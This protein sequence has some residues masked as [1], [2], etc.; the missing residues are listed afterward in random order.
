MEVQIGIIQA[1]QSQAAWL[2]IP[3]RIFSFLGL[4]EFYLLV[5][6]LFYWC[7][8]PRFGLRIG[9]LLGLT[10][11]LNDALKIAFHLPRPY[12][13][14]GEVAVLNTYPSFGLPSAHAQGAATFWGY[15]AA[16][17]RRWWVTALAAV[18]VVLIGVSRVYE[19]VH[20]PM[21]TVAGW[22]VGLAVLA[23]FLRFEEPAAARLARL[24]VQRQV[25]AAA[26]ASLGLLALSLAAVASLG[27]WHLP[28]AWVTEALARSGEP[29]D[30]LYPRDGLIAT[31]MLFGFAAG[32]ALQSHRGSMCSADARAGVLLL[33]Y[34]F[35]IAVAGAIWLGF[36]LVVPDGDGFAAYAL[37][38]LR[39]TVAAGWVSFGAPEVFYRMN[40]AKREEG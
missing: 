14:S 31:G 25:L 34:L 6:P 30:P 17:A 40:L 26:L 22:V 16:K 33:R 27:D 20:F 39:A 37:T 28:Q 8:D 21:D 15:I 35:G 3:M 7:R 19:G 29:I 2:D 12:W 24:P 1:L 5:I 23:V 11:G 32:A 18:L 10:A 36:G 38:Y 13:V 4:P 9:L